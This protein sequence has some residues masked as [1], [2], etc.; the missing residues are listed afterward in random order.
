MLLSATLIILCTLASSDL[1]AGGPP[2]S[3]L[4][5]LWFSSN[6]QYVLP[7]DDSTTVVLTAEP[8]HTLFRIPANNNP[9][10]GASTAEQVYSDLGKMK[11]EF[12]LPCLVGKSPLVNEP[13]S[14]IVLDSDELNR[15]ALN[16]ADIIVPKGKSA[17]ET[18][19]VYI[20]IDE[21]GHVLC[22]DLTKNSRDRLGILAAI[23]L[24]T[25]KQWVFE[26]V[27]N[28]TKPV[29]CIGQLELHVKT[30]ENNRKP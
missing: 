30:P 25:A 28:H 9:P 1:G 12:S 19:T 6:G 11:A 10:G 15:R 16:I 21:S 26:P 29:L 24:E 14:P 3:S 2:H 20:A 17:P 23:A 8:L 22:A 18:V 5:Q 4:R 7:Q 27:L 13:G